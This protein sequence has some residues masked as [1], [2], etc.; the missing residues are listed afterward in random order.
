MTKKKKKGTS[1]IWHTYSNFPILIIVKSLSH[2][3]LFAT[4]WT[5]AYQASPDVSELDMTGQ[6]HY[7][8]DWKS[9][10]GIPDSAGTFLCVCVIKEHWM[11]QCPF[12]YML[13][14]PAFLLHGR[15]E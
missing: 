14:I 11:L 5:V 15:T 10:I 12:V 4:P 8:K 13:P 3:Q 7:D 1:Q 6:L 2:V 9:T